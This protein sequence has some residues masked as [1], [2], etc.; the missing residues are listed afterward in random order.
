MYFIQLQLYKTPLYFVLI[1]VCRFTTVT[2]GNIKFYITQNNHNYFS[3][4]NNIFFPQEI[5]NLLKISLAGFLE[6]DSYV[7][8]NVF[9]V[10]INTILKTLYSDIISLFNRHCIFIHIYN[11]IQNMTGFKLRS[12]YVLTLCVTLG[13]IAG[14]ASCLLLNVNVL[15][16]CGINFHAYHEIGLGYIHTSCQLEVMC[17]NNTRIRVRTFINFKIKIY[18]SDQQTYNSQLYTLCP[19]LFIYSWRWIYYLRW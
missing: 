12:I 13:I 14:R 18:K 9:R 5:L 19:I 16:A 6:A 8:P 17:I 4:S 11:W 7:Y 3:S 1:Y 15:K 2:Q 10:L